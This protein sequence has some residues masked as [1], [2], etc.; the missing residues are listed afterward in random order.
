MSKVYKVIEVVGCSDKDYN[1]AIKNAVAEAAKTL[2]GMAWFEVKE[3]RGGLKD[4][5]ITEYQAIIKVGF[6]LID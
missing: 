4:G 6:R 5:A 1:D 3:M 2:K